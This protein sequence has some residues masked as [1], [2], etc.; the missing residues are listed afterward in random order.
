[1]QMVLMCWSA[2]SW[3]RRLDS[4]KASGSGHW[5]RC[6]RGFSLEPSKLWRCC[7]IPFE[8]RLPKK[9]HPRWHNKEECPKAKANW[10][11]QMKRQLPTSTN[12]TYNMS[13]GCNEEA[14]LWE[15]FSCLQQ[16]PSWPP[17]LE[18]SHSTVCRALTGSL[19]TAFVLGVDRSI[20]ERSGWID[21]MCRDMM[22]IIF[23]I[24]SIAWISFKDIFQ[25]WQPGYKYRFSKYLALTPDATASCK[26][27]FR[28]SLNWNHVGN[29]GNWG[30]ECAS[31]IITAR[32]K[33]GWVL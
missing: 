29:Y 14:L 16:F 30:W 1:M 27:M 20:H 28:W 9:G 6:L 25:K 4:M 32:W 33:Q 10:W 2:V 24:I 11:R 3:N 18:N 7:W 12:C 23:E 21:W 19:S 5:F 26:S 22:E 31:L 8:T 17:R 13:W 15:R